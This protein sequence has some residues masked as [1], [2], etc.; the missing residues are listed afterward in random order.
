M[1]DQGTWSLNKI[2]SA[3][4]N[5]L[6]AG[7]STTTRMNFSLEQLSHIVLASRNSYITNMLTQG[8]LKTNGIIQEINC[9]PLDCEQF[10]LC[11]DTDT[12]KNVKHFELPNTFVNSYIGSVNR[13]TPFA[14][15]TD[16]HYMY[17]KYRNKSLINRPY[18]V[19]RSHEGITH[20][21]LFNPPTEI[22]DK[23]SF[24]GVLV[25]PMDVNKYSCCNLNPE[26][27]T[28][29]VPPGAVDYIIKDITSNWASWYYRFLGRNA[30]GGIKE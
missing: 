23:I 11:C 24:A 5:N 7:L 26:T 27:S 16:N 28:Y 12:N 29:P 3:V 9:I 6:E 13:Q 2:T 4:R 18:V 25:N 22:I 15:Y 1:N 21:F 8:S 14:Y 17:N 10:S 20:G 19:L 30:S